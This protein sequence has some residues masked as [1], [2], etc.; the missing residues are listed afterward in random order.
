MAFTSIVFENPF[1]GNT[2]EAPV[3]FSWTTGFFGFFPALFRGDYKWAAIQL[4]LALLTAGLSQL[5]FMFIYNKIYIKEL[6]GSGF[7]AKSIGSGD[8]DFASGK[9]GIEIPQ[10]ES[11]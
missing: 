11:K 1:N 9:L 5:V 3:G 4:V 7:K 6:I 8:M 2:K 10:V